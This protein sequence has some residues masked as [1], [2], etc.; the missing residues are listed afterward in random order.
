MSIIKKKEPFFYLYKYRIYIMEEGVISSIIFLLEIKER[1]KIFTIHVLPSSF[2][3][4]DTGAN[5][6]IIVLSFRFSLESGGVGSDVGSIF[7]H[8]F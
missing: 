2:I 7:A 3:Y 5:I 4:S 8:R 1:K 6:I